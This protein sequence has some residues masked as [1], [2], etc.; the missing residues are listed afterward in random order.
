MADSVIFLILTLVMLS[1]LVVI[2][3]KTYRK[4]NRDRMEDPKYRM[5]DDD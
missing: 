1:I 5:M 3:I 2:T 4:K